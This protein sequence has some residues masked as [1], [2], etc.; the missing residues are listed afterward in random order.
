MLV[1]SD[2]E[3]QTVL[4]ASLAA[5]LQDVARACRRPGHAILTREQAIALLNAPGTRDVDLGWLQ[6]HPTLRYHQ[7]WTH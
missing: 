3:R 2:P 6:N 7:P 5:D 4:Q 1:L